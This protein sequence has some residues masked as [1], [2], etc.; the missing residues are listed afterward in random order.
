MKIDFLA[1]TVKEQERYIIKVTVYESSVKPVILKYKGIPEIYMR[2]EGFTNGA[3][4]E[5]IIDMSIRSQHVQYDLQT[6]DIK[7]DRNN[8]KELREFYHDHTGKELSDK[9]LRSMGFYNEDGFL[10]NGAV[11]FMDDYNDNKTAVQCSLFRGLNKGSERIIT[12][13]R[14][15][16][17]LIRIIRYMTDFVTQRMNHSMIKLKDSRIN[18][19][20]YPKR[21]LF[22]G[23][24]NAVVHRDYYLDGTEIQMDMFV[25]RLEI[26]SPGGFYRH[27][28]MEKTYDLTNIISKRRNELISDVLVACNVMEAAGTGF[29]KIMEEYASYNDSHRPYIYSKS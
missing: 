12:I 17:N 26:S 3:T 14:Y 28:P 10:S 9:L 29:D 24:I 1:Y 16:G 18:I 25:D 20:A 15:K 19:D 4:Y 7:Y 11:L 27:E 2:R 13:N 5:E 6:S 23:I 8:F 22:E 21:A